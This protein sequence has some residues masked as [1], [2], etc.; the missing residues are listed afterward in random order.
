MTKL[1]TNTVLPVGVL[2]GSASQLGQINVPKL[3]GM[4]IAVQGSTGPMG[5]AGADA[6]GALTAKGLGSVVHSADPVTTFVVDADEFAVADSTDSF[7]AKRLSWA[8]L[9][10]AILAWFGPAT[11]TLSNKDLTAATNT[12]PTTL[13]TL[14]GAQA[15]TNKTISGAANTLSNIAVSSL[16]ATGTA[17][18]K[19]YLRG[20]G[21]W[22]PITGGL[23]MTD[24]HDGTWTVK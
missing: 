1:N 24:N 16:A 9:K 7:K 13:V 15:I 6:P 11:A 2:A 17:D 3:G 8:S 18:A 20:D 12:F 4:L 14:T 5:P 23:S 10:A 19:T 21:Q 22:H